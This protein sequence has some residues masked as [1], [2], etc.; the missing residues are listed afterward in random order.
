MFS[1]T[2]VSGSCSAKR[3]VMRTPSLSI[4]I[5]GLPS[6]Y[7]HFRYVSGFPEGFL[8]VTVRCSFC[9]G[10]RLH[11]L[12]LLDTPGAVGKADLGKFISGR[13][14]T[15]SI[16]ISPP[17]GTPPVAPFGYKS[18]IIPRPRSSPSTECSSVSPEVSLNR[19]LRFQGRSWRAFRTW[20]NR[21]SQFGAGNVLMK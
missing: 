11:T 17:P 1:L 6:S 18:I 15:C 3:K 14:R 12:F 4:F 19:S 13:L 9:S 5:T 8:Y 16:G 7:R 21:S 20:L 10:N 2:S